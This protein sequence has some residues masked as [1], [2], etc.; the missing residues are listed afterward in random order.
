MLCSALI[1]FSIS[2]MLSMLTSALCT[3]KLCQQGNSDA[4]TPHLNILGPAL[5]DLVKDANTP[6]RLAAERCAFYVMQLNKGITIQ[7]ISFYITS[8]HYAQHKISF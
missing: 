5:A 3:A 7:A 8:N 1:L 6:V 4:V 2:V